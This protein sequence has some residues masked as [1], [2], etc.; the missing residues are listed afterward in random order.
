[1]RLPTPLAPNGAEIRSG[2]KSW[3]KDFKLLTSQWKKGEIDGYGGLVATIMS[4]LT[5]E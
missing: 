3:E 1:M 5:V 2:S 4:K